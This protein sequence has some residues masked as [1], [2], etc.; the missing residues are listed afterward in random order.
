MAAAALGSG[1]ARGSSLSRE[2]ASRQPPA[3]LAS[4][5]GP[6][7]CLGQARE[8]LAVKHGVHDLHGLV[9]DGVVHLGGIKQMSKPRRR[10]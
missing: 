9:E 1:A 8:A 3:G 4:R 5:A 10:L 2:A 7:T 6:G